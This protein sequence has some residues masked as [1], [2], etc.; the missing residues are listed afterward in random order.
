MRFVLIVIA[1]LALAAPATASAPAKDP[2]VPALQR[3]VASLKAQVATLKGQFS[4]LSKQLQTLNDKNDCY[5]GLSTDVENIVWTGL[6]IVVHYLNG[7]T[8]PAAPPRF[9]DNGACARLGIT[10]PGK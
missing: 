1:V 3:Q 9:A 8:Q 10:R 4:T 7:Q 5:Y 6:G 2:R